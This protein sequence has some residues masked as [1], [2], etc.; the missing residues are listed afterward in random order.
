MEGSSLNDFPPEL[1]VVDCTQH[2]AVTALKYFHKVRDHHKVRARYGMYQQS[3]PLVRYWC[4]KSTHPNFL[5]RYDPNMR[6][7]VYLRPCPMCFGIPS[8]ALNMVDDPFE[9]VEPES[10]PTPMPNALLEC[11]DYGDI[12]WL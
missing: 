12:I 5:R 1:C 3:S 4:G 10:E 6:S 11:E 8:K 2:G 9:E 7:M